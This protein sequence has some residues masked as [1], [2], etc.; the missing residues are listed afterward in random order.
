MA[1]NEKQLKL[2]L[3]ADPEADD[4][5]LATMAQQLRSG[6]LNLDEV[7]SVDVARVG[8]I[9]ENAKGGDVV[10]WGQLLITLVGAGSGLTALLG[11]V[12]SWLS[13]DERRSITLEING[14][15]LSITGISSEQQQQMINTWLERHPRRRTS[16]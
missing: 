7:E 10:T 16:R 3:E 9:P 5:E 2:T 14:D 6:I 11:I 1:E 4:K 8:T 12:Q 13:K 15:K